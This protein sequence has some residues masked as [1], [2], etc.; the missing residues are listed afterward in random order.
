MLANRIHIFVMVCCQLTVINTRSASGSYDTSCYQ[1]C[2]QEGASG[3]NA[4]TINMDAP[5][6]NL[7]NIKGQHAN[8]PSKIVR[9]HYRIHVLPLL[10]RRG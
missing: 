6:R 1:A 4:P 7:Q 5:A 2:S 3:F 9:Q 10:N 8:Q